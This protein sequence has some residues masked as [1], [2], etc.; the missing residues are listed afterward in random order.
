VTRVLRACSDVLLR[1][2][3][4]PF[5]ARFSG[6]KTHAWLTQ[7]TR[8]PRPVLSPRDV[9]FL[10]AKAR[11]SPSTLSS[12]VVGSSPLISLR[13]SFTLNSP[14]TRRSTSWAKWWATLVSKSCRNGLKAL[15]YRGTGV[16]A[17]SSNRIVAAFTGFYPFL[18][19][20]G[21]LPH[22]PTAEVLR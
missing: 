16:E 20:P 8:A 18:G 19:Y 21:R 2:R 7:P 5:G 4:V 14:I 9:L 3:A 17:Y 1:R 13:C 22:R 10:L 15:H 12:L 6:A 11:L